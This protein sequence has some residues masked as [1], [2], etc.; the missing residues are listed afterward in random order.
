MLENCNQH[1]VGEYVFYRQN[2]ICVISDVT[3]DDL[4][5]M[6][7]QTYY[8]LSSVSNENNKFF[9]PVNSPLT[10]EMYRLLTAKEIDTIILRTGENDEDVW[11]DDDKSRTAFFDT[12]L[13]SGNRADIIMAME[14]KM[15]LKER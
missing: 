11:I 1:N 12:V 2:G 7:I 15:Y 8:V 9:V 14:V 4:G 5:V 10:K 6:G 3:T 13:K